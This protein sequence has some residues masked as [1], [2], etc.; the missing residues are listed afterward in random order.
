ML[1]INVL[2][3]SSEIAG[4]S[5]GIIAIDEEIHLSTTGNRESKR[6]LDIFTRFKI[7]ALIVRPSPEYRM[8]DFQYGVEEQC[9]NDEN[10]FS[11]V[12]DKAVCKSKA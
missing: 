6:I 7:S 2:R 11:R 3:A 5:V 8:T 12:L 9:V 1:E 10:N 4:F